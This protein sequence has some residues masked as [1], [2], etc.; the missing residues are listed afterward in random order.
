MTFTIITENDVSQWDDE[1]G[2]TY[3]FPNK[4]LSTLNL[5]LLHYNNTF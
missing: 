5:S 1:T 2:T 3:H 4:H